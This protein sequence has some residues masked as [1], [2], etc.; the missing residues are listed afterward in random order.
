[1]KKFR[2]VDLY[3]NELTSRIADFTV[4]RIMRKKIGLEYADRINTLK[5]SIVGLAKLEGS[6]LWTDAV[7]DEIAKK[8]A[9]I[10]RLEE[11][12]AAVMKRDATFAPTKADK[13]FKKSLKGLHVDDD[14]IALAIIEWFDAY[15]V[16]V[17]SSYLLKDILRAIGGKESFTELCDSHGQNAVVVDESRALNMLY[18][19]TFGAC[20]SKG[21]IKAANVP[22]IIWEKYATESREAK[23][24]AKKAA[25]AAE[26]K[27][28]AEKAA[29]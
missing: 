9:E 1:M 16:D 11:E 26:K 10:V 19:V 3:N 23:A 17:R 8:Q 25:K 14:R 7:R 6:V 15:G 20:V 12:K 4:C 2:N 21:S 28:D 13:S 29:A 22:S 24:A 27:A 18:W 5:E